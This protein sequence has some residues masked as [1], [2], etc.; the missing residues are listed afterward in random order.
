MVARVRWS[1]S[2]AFPLEQ[3]D[4][5][6]LHLDLTRDEHAVKLDAHRCRAVRRLE[7]I[8]EASRGGPMRKQLITTQVAVHRKLQHAVGMQGLENVRREPWTHV[9]HRPCRIRGVSER[10][11]IGILA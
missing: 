4:L 8:T 11:L 10:A 7:A 2:L 5:V 6:P 3:A 9:R 1:A